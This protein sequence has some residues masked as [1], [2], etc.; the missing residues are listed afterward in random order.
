MTSDS[1]ARDIGRDRKPL[2]LIVDDEPDACANLSDILSEL[3]YR[4]DI[5]ANGFQALELATD[6]AYDVALLDLKMPHM[7]GVTLYHRL[8]KLSPRTAAVIVTAYGGDARL[9]ALGNSIDAVCYK[10]VDME[11]LLNTVQYLSRSGR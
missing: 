1:L 4:V 5:A 9:L 2:I 6:Q 7:D 8:K 3:D 10:P 11:I